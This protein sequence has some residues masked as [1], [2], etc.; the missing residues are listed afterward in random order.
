METG[1]HPWNVVYNFFVTFRASENPPEDE[2]NSETNVSVNVSNEISASSVPEGKSEETKIKEE[3]AFEEG[4]SQEIP[5]N[6]EEQQT[7]REL[8]KNKDEKC[9]KIVFTE[10]EKRY[11]EEYAEG[12]SSPEPDENDSI[13]FEMPYEQAM[14]I[15]SERTRKFQ[16]GIIKNRRETK[17]LKDYVEQMTKINEEI[18]ALKA[19][20]EKFKEKQQKKKKRQ[21]KKKKQK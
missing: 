21:C 13:F 18:K 14:R 19:R 11:L 12:K 16:E 15:L 1:S 4:T 2:G 7:S 3:E 17:I 9:E 20:E 8:P 10:E 5:L 6:D